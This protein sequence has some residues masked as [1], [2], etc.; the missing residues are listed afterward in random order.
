MRYSQLSGPDLD[1]FVR[2]ISHGC[3]A[4][5]YQRKCPR[6]SEDEAWLWAADHWRK[7]TDRALD[8][9]A[10][11]AVNQEDDIAARERRN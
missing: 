8:I 7:F 6:A 5:T 4:K 2:M 11:L 9:L 3:A 1:Y 10:V